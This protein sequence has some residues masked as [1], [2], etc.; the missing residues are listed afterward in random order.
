MIKKIMIILSG[1]FLVVGLT[2]IFAPNALAGTGNEWCLTSTASKCIN[3]W[4]GGPFVKLATGHLTG[5]NNDFTVVGAGGGNVTLRFSGNSSWADGQHCIGDAFN[6]PDRADTS[7]DICNGVDY[8][9]GT[10]FT[11]GGSGCPIGYSWFHN[12]HW[13]GY[14]GPQDSNTN[15][16]PFYLNKGTKFCYL[17]TSPE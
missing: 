1:L 14:L 2:G 17:S 15:G 12:N 8:G 5:P 3:A 13:G 16:S 7:L 9:W 4:G 11:V 10:L 6:D